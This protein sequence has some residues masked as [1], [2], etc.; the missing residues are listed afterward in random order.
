MPQLPLI[1]AEPLAISPQEQQSRLKFLFDDNVLEEKKANISDLENKVKVLEN[2]VT[3]Y[4]AL[5]AE[6]K[7]KVQKVYDYLVSPLSN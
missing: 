5:T 1:R 4:N 7:T 3:E 2:L 6:E